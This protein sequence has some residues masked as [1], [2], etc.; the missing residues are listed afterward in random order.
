VSDTRLRLL[1]AANELFRRRG[2][3]GTSVKEITAAAAAPTGSL[4]HFFPGGKDDLTRAVIETS[5]AAYRQLFDL[6]A[7]AADDSGAVVTDFFGGAAD[8]LEETGFIDPCPIGAVARE[9]ASTNDALRAATD[10]V[11]RS[12]ID[13]VAARFEADGVGRDVADQLAATVVATLEGAFVLARARRDAGPVRSAGRWLRRLV[14]AE[15]AAAR[16]DVG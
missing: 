4:Y 3:N 11:F 15:R 8:V 9:V 5:G 10:R 2:Y 14:D 16:A 12:W 7:D 1:T 6:V 13:A